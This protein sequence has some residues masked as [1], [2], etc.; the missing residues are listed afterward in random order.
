[1]S[2]AQEFGPHGAELAYPQIAK[3]LSLRGIRIADDSPASA[4]T[5]SKYNIV[6]NDN[7]KVI[8]GDNLTFYGF[9]M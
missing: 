9:T 6:N 5:G 2:I 4:S 7:G 3:L 1:M 8:A